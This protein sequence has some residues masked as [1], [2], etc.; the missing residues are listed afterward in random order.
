M[1]G[2]DMSD[3]SL[4]IQQFRKLAITKHLNFLIGSGV[5]TPAVPLMSWVKYDS[6]GAIPEEDE[7][8][9]NKEL[10]RRIRIISYLAL[11]NTAGGKCKGDS[12]LWRC[13]G[14]ID[15]EKNQTDLQPSDPHK[16]LGETIHEYKRFVQMIIR[17]L[18]LSN[19]RE[20]PRSATIFTTNYDLLLETAIDECLAENNFVFNDGARGYFNRY[21]DSS[22]FNQVVSYRGLNDNYTDEL[23]SIT[24]IK[25]HGSVN[26]E[27]G[28]Y[29][30]EQ[31]AVRNRVVN[32][33]VI[34]PP[35]GHEGEATFLSNHFHDMLRVFQLELDKPQSVLFVIGFSFQDDH[36]ARMLRRALDNRELKVVIFGYSDQ[37]RH[38]ILQNIFHDSHHPAS[39]PNFQIITPSDFNDEETEKKEGSANPVKKVRKIDLEFVTDMLQS[40]SL[41]ELRSAE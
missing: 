35:N 34:V 37:D 30:E 10:V 11:A 17:L 36:I 3:K 7:I 29:S 22:N 24:L 9:R 5:S 26:W 32:S 4:N 38:V 13:V 8:R 27:K 1:G 16:I 15:A 2:V 31:I 41:K 23:P 20:T 19:A 28:G 39:Y 12:E 21:L 25:P 18:N 14:N 33:P 40:A 6:K